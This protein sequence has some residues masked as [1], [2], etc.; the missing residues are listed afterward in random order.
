MLSTDMTYAN[1]YQF[2]GSEEEGIG[3]ICEDEADGIDED[4]T[5]MAIYKNGYTTGEPVFRIDTNFWKEP[6]TFIYILF[7]GF[8]CR[9]IT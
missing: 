4:R 2:L 6:N 9:K 8:C 5:K 1:I 3:T 7:Q